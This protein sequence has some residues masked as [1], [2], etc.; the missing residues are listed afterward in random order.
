M[1]AD[2]ARIAQLLNRLADTK[3][4]MGHH[5][6]RIGVLGPDLGSSLGAVAVA[7]MELGHARLLFRWRHELLEEVR[8]DE[9]PVGSMGAD[10]L[11]E[12]RTVS[13]WVALITKTYCVEDATHRLISHVIDG[14]QDRRLQTAKLQQELTDILTYTGGWVE[15][16]ATDAPGVR[17]AAVVAVHE[18]VPALRTLLAAYA[19]E[20][21]AD[22]DPGAELRP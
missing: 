10:A 5:L 3:F 1:T 21:V 16:F 15:Q 17:Q 6:V 14:L 9:D 20:T 12:V 4:L 22:F 7:Q 18:V 19:P 8:A 13:S 2:S 11:P